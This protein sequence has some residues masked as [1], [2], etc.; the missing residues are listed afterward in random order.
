MLRETVEKICSRRED[1]EEREASK[2]KRVK[3]TLGGQV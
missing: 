1:H 3:A 2:K